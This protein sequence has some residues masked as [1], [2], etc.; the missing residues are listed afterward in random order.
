MEDYIAKKMEELKKKQTQ[1]QAAIVAKKKAEDE[2]AAKK[3]AEEEAAIKKKAEEEAAKKKAEEEAAK[4]KADEEAAKKKAE[5]EAAKKKADEEAAAKKKIEDEAAAAKKKIEDEAA[6]KKKAEEEKAAKLKEEI[7]SIPKLIFIVPYRNRQQHQEFFA[8]HMKRIMEDHDSKSYKIYYIH[9]NDKRTFNRGGMKNIGFLMVKDK[10]PKY[11]KDITLV[12]NDVDT[13]P[14]T[15]NFL[16]Y[17]TTTGVVKHFY[18]YKFALGGIVSIKAGDF[19]KSNGFPNFWAWGY[20]DNLLKKRVE[21]AGLRINYQQFYPIHDKNILQMKDG[22]HRIINRKEYD[23]YMANTPAGIRN[24]HN[25]K[26]TV[27][28][29]NGFVDVTAFDVENPNNPEDLID[30]DARKG[31]RPFGKKRGGSMKMA[32]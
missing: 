7:D 32:L 13:M 28:E 1:E 18:G 30:Y 4:K 27:N 24:V 5:E 14:Y 25:L 20:E 21:A 6:A 10:Y 16:N 31:N 8:N 19:E 26:Y 12:F 3:K 29:K 15:K 23:A 11:Y 9:Q 17:N 22:F 2:A